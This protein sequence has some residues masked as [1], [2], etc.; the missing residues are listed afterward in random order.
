MNS[1]QTSPHHVRRQLLKNKELN[2]ESVGKTDMQTLS[3]VAAVPGGKG[4]VLRLIM[5]ATDAMPLRA[6]T[7]VD[8]A[9]RM[10]RAIPCEQVQV[11]HANKLGS[12]VNNVDLDLA[13]ENARQLAVLAQMHAMAFFPELLGKLLHGQD[14]EL[15]LTDFTTTSETIFAS[16]P[17]IAGKL[18]QK[19]SK[20]GGDAVIYAAAHSA[21]QDTDQLDIEPL[22][23]VSL[24]QVAADRIVSVGCQ[25]ERLFYH[26]RMAMRPLLSGEVELVDTAQLFTHHVSPPYFTARGGEQLLADAMRD[27]VDISRCT[28][29]AAR[30]DINRFNEQIG[31]HHG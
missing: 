17:D 9:L 30:R 29:F 28:D 19:G 2:V 24:S 13:Q 21:F 27:G 23:D 15:D 22:L 3:D 12:R 14:C 10:A 11:V 31:V 7:Y 25:Q 18:A 8:A 1:R 4:T 26:T 16:R 5:G 6:L 20:H